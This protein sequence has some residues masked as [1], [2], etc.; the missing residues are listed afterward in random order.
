MWIRIRYMRIEACTINH[1]LYQE[2]EY[3]YDFYYYYSIPIS[4]Y[5][6]APLFESK[7]LTFSM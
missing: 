7:G 2:Y 4:V 5:H 1:Q 6:L 3:Y